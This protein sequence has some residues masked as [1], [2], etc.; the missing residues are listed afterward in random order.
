MSALL[1]IWVGGMIP[2][3]AI[4]AA[5]FSRHGD[6]L[7]WMHGLAVVLWPLMLLDALFAMDRR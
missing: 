5:D 4:A 3:A 1:W 7:A 2:V 6:T